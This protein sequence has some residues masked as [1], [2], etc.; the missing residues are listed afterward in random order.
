MAITLDEAIRLIIEEVNRDNPSNANAVYHLQKA[1]ETMPMLLCEL[2]F[3]GAPVAE[4]TFT[5]VPPEMIGTDA[6]YGLPESGD[7][8]EGEPE[9]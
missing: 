3:L 8:D 1:N 4:P 7:F 2:H 9:E 6:D 5:E